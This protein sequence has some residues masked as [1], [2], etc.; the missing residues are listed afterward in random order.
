LRIVHASAGLRSAT[1]SEALADASPQDDV[2]PQE[3]AL[4]KTLALHEVH[5]GDV[6]VPRA[7]I[8]AVALQTTLADVLAVFRDAGHSRLPAWRHSTTRA[9]AVHI[10]DFVGYLTA[11]PQ[12]AA[13]SSAGE[14]KGNRRRAVVWC[15]AL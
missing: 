11:G 4:L 9:A 12:G 13:S 2:S 15:M 1:T 3:R 5:V 8:V 10:R 14:R 7:D 6:M